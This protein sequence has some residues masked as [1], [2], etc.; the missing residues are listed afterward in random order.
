MKVS[1]ST[2]KSCLCF[3]L[4]EYNFFAKRLGITVS[5]N[6]YICFFIID[7]PHYSLPEIVNH[8]NDVYVQMVQQYLELI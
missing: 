4:E 7:H 2:V 1:V 5:L 8:F 3:T 6:E